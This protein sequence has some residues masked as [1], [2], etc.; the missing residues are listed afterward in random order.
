MARKLFSEIWLVTKRHIGATIAIAS[1][2]FLMTLSIVLVF[3]E[4]QA[5][6]Q[7]I[8]DFMDTNGAK[9]IQFLDDSDIG[10]FDQETLNFVEAFDNIE[11]SFET[12]TVFDVFNS[13]TKDEINLFPAKS[14]RGDIS[15]VVQ[16]VAGRMPKAGEAIISEN[17]AHGFKL[18]G[19]TGE[20]S[21]SNQ[22][23]NV[24]GIFKSDEAYLD[25]KNFALI[26]ESSTTPMPYFYSKVKEYN[27]LPTTQTLILNMISPFGRE[28][29]KI[30]SKS[31]A[32]L[33][34]T[35]ENNLGSFANYILI[36][37]LFLGIVL[38]TV[39]T[40]IDAFLNQKD[41]GRR[42]ALGATKIYISLLMIFRGAL[43]STVGAT[44]GGVVSI[45]YLYFYYLSIPINFLVAV[46]IFVLIIGSLGSLLPSLII[47]NRDPLRAIRTP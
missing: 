44:I 15:K 25:F 23:W 37:V 22:S 30:L 4:S 42:R 13:L 29:I 39:A 20:I 11:Y 3:G 10:Y 17:A 8:R 12:S 5:S 2:S 43:V 1:I 31:L 21:S 6:I 33:Q 47:I 45:F 14:F 35:I 26:Y 36:L 9:T 18:V 32:S 24:V 19:P 27:E 28:D 46:I 16:L 41:I 38:I 34:N 40:L 7:N